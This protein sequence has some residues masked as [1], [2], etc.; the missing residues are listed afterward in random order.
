MTARRNIM[1]K[2]VI[3]EISAVDVP[4]QEHAR[5]VIFKRGSP[6]QEPRL[7]RIEAPEGCDWSKSRETALQALQKLAEERAAAKSE[8][9]PDAYA[10]VMATP[11]GAELYQR[12]S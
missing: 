8:T 2:F 3:G 5:A 12:A 4:C 6:P 1:R 7:E 11:E 9:V 10:A